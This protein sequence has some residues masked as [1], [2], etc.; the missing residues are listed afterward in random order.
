LNF[1]RLKVVR[2]P[3][4]RLVSGVLAADVADVL[5]RAVRERGRATLAVPGGATPKEF[6]A[7]LGQHD[8]P[9]QLIDVVPTDERNVA[10]RDPRS[11][12]RMIREA[13]PLVA[14][15]FIALRGSD[16]SLDEAAE[17]LAD[18]V[19]S[20]LPIDAV[21]VGMGVDAHIASLFPGDARLSLRSSK[22]AATVMVSHPTGLEP[23]LSLGPAAL[24]GARWKALLI[25]G[26]DK[27]AALARAL[28]SS[29]PAVAPVCLLFEGDTAP[30]VYC[31]D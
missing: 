17:G 24:A 13:L 29:D 2:E 4:L 3:D 15:R 18:R 11:N 31:S 10:A 12:E 25:A 30:S 23:R 26:E 19:K 6:L 22:A 27:R 7:C 8:L 1:P 14:E 5:R 20:L 21:V 16:V 28:Q 9:W